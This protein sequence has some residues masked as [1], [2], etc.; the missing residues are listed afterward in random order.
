MSSNHDFYIFVIFRTIASVTKLEFFA[1]IN[2]TAEA[3]KILIRLSAERNTI[4]TKTTTILV[5]KIVIPVWKTAV[6]LDSW[7]RT[8]TES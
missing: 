6:P 1:P 8:M 4:Q 3:V 2:A 5:L 7:I